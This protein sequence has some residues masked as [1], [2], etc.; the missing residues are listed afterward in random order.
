VNHV[1]V[2]GP[3]GH[4]IE[5]TLTGVHVS[6]IGNYAG[7]LARANLDE[8]MTDAEREAV[9]LAAMAMVNAP[10][11]YPDLLA[12]GLGDLGWH[13]RLLI[14][15][16]GSDKAFI[17][18]QLVALAGKAAGLDW[19]CHDSNADQVTPAQLAARP[20]VVPATIG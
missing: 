15:L 1:V 7:H 8:P 19:M 11:N 18:S 14:R 6:P 16:C 9:V 13:W 12:I 5:A 3:D 20:G 10:Y 4:V 2:A 17:C